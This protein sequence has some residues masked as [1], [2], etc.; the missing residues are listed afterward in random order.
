[1][2]DTSAAPEASSARRVALAARLG[3]WP[4]SSSRSARSS[5]PRAAALDRDDAF[6]GLGVHGTDMRA[7][8]RRPAPA[9]CRAPVP[10]A[11]ARAPAARGLRERQRTLWRTGREIGIR[12]LAVLL[13]ARQ[14]DQIAEILERRLAVAPL[15]GIH[16]LLLSRGS[17]PS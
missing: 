17:R 12:L 5:S 13:L 1:M 14:G 15:H 11:G 6:P 8:T 3:A 2:T 16:E 9:A 4:A 7:R 10:P